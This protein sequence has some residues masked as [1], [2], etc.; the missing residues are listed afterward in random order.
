[1]AWKNAGNR[2]SDKKKFRRDL[3]R[4]ES[5]EMSE[6]PLQALQKSGDFNTRVQFPSPASSWHPNVA[7]AGEMDHSAAF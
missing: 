6:P 2:H 5:C 1:M 7:D 3:N 4:P